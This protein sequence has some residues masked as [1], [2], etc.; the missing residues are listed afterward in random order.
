MRLHFL[1]MNSI[2]AQ[3]LF[4]KEIIYKNPPVQETPA[5]EIIVE[6][7]E[8]VVAVAPPGSPTEVQQPGVPK[9]VALKLNHGVLVLTEKISEDE[10]VFLGKILSAVGLSLSQIDLIETHQTPPIDYAA[11][12]AQKTATKL[13][14][15][16]VA[17]SKLNWDLSLS[18][19]TLRNVSGIDFLLA[20]DLGTVSTDTSHKKILWEALKVMFGK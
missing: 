2:L 3:Y 10:K 13:I 20:N 9:P 1:L 16:G 11:F 19:Y 5:Q 8:S 15:F 7:K 18:P 12:I 6:K 17:P 4:S 14:S